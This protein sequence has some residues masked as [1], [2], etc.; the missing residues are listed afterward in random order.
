MARSAA[1][2]NARPQFN[3]LLEPITG[4]TGDAGVHHLAEHGE[5]WLQIAGHIGIL[6]FDG[7]PAGGAMHR[8]SCLLH[9]FRHVFRDL[10]GAVKP[11]RGHSEFL[12]GNGSGLAVV[13]A[14]QGL[15]DLL[16]C[17][18]MVSHVCERVI[19]ELRRHV[20]QHARIGRHGIVVL[21]GMM[22]LMLG[23]SHA[24]CRKDGCRGGGDDN[25]VAHVMSV[26]EFGRGILDAQIATTYDPDH[27]SAPEHIDW[28]ALR[29]AS[30][31][32]AAIPERI[33][34]SARTQSVPKSVQV[35]ARGDRPHAMYFVISGDVH[36]VRSSL[37]GN[38]VVLQRAQRGFLA[39]ASLD[40]PRYHCDAIAI[41]PSELLAIPRKA[42]H[43]A[44]A[45][46]AFAR[47]WM[48]HLAGELRRVR[49][50]AERS[51]LKTAEARIV[52]YV[53]TEGDSGTV[54]LNNSKKDWA[55]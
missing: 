11:Q 26:G 13:P 19:H 55:G 25:P 49:A 12:L 18:Q 34:R 51:T 20:H 8:A 3:A 45:D 35:F 54:T 4:V 32:L 6:R 30:P 48:A 2:V 16:K 38:Q 24:G 42:F 14:R 10:V 40:Q 37:T 33:C 47:I 29:K 7:K 5:C 9:S 23:N 27:M 15:A 28:T 21:V 50:Q 43:D 52:H 31:L 46:A 1:T 36:L 41:W 22:S 39:E 44:L 53:E 17:K